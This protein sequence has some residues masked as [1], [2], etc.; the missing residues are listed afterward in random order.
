MGCC[1]TIIELIL[2]LFLPPL[3]VLF[4]AGCMKDLAINV[5]L[6]LLFFIPGVIHAYIV[7][8]G[9][10]K[11]GHDCNAEIDRQDEVV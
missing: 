5:L 6:T 1:C 2:A 4:H 11:A 9:S 7:I 8:L 10:E 3:A